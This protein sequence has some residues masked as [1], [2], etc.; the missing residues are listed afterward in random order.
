MEGRDATYED[1][2]HEFAS[3]AGLNNVR[4]KFNNLTNLLKS[5]GIEVVGKKPKNERVYKEINN[6]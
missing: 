4:K 2:I 6:I 5:K 1:I 3:L